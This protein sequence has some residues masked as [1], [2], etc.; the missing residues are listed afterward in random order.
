[1]MKGGCANWIVREIKKFE[2]LKSNFNI[3][4]QPSGL[5]KRNWYQKI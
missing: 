5:L 2:V 3:L 1:M 4:K